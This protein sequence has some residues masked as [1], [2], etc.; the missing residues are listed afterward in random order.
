VAG[1]DGSGDSARPGFGWF[2]GRDALWTLYAVNAYGDFQLT[3]DELEFLLRRQGPDGKIIHEWSQT[4]EIV[5][6][7][8]LPYMFAS[9]DATPLLLMAMNDYFQ[10]SGDVGFLKAHWASGNA[11]SGNLPGSIRPAGQ[12]SVRKDRKGCRKSSTRG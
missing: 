11:A 1:I 4:A 6:W 12:H 10:I 5:D 3:R 2:F 9:A 8:S 7:K